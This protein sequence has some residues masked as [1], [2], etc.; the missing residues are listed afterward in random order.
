VLSEDVCAT[1]VGTEVMT[2]LVHA[3][4]DQ[5]ITVYLKIEAS[6]ALCRALRRARALIGRVG[7]EEL[8]AFCIEQLSKAFR[9]V[10]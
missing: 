1:R 6:W 2:E 5:G 7:R 3:D 9:E 4:D 10:L 8:E